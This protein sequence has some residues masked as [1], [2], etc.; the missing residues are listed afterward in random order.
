M[1]LFEVYNGLVKANSLNHELGLA[2]AIKHLET[3]Y[4]DVLRK[5]D[6]YLQIES[7][8]VNNASLPST[9]KQQQ[10]AHI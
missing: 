4:G 9:P 5:N 10:P 3:K 2:P 1:C 6:I 7:T 8:F